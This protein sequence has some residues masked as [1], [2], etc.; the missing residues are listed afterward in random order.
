MTPLRCWLRSPIFFITFTQLDQGLPLLRIYDPFGECYNLSSLLVGGFDQSNA[1]ELESSLI[2]FPSEGCKRWGGPFR[3][4]GPGQWVVEQRS[5]LDGGEMRYV[6]GQY[7][8][9]GEGHR[10]WGFGN[11]RTQECGW[12]S[13]RRQLRQH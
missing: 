5:P 6:A 4:E 1:R 12:G 2:G 11:S 10:W 3:V 9:D 7:W 13:H 8:G